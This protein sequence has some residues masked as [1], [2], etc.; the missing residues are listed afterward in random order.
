MPKFAPTINTSEVTTGIPKSVACLRTKRLPAIQQ[1]LIN[2]VSAP[3][4]K[5][6]H[7]ILL[8]AIIRF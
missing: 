7:P 5:Y 4:P 2:A 8:A 1:I 6:K 3:L